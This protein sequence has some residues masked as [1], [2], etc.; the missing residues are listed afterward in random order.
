[1]K[2]LFVLLAVATILSA[3]N[4]GGEG[5]LTGVL[6]RAPSYDQTPYGMTRVPTGSFT[7]GPSDQDVPWALNAKAKTVSLT[8]FWMDQTEI[9]NNEYRQFVYWVRDSLAYRLL[10]EQID[11]YFISENKF[12]ETIDPPLIDWSKEI[13]WGGQEEHE[14]LAPLFYPKNERFFNLKRIDTRK[15]IYHYFWI[16]YKQ[17]AQKFTFDN[18]IR[19]RYNYKT[20]QYDGEVYNEE[21]VKVPV[22]D[23]S[24]F[25]M[26]GE[27]PIYP[28]TLCWISDFTNSY[29]EPMANTYF[30][31]PSFDD[32]PVV[33]VNWVEAR[34][35]CIWRTRLKNNALRA[36][37][38]NATNNYQL[39][40]EA[41][42]EYAARGGLQLVAYPWGGYYTR[43]DEG[44]FMANYKPLRGN[45]AEDGE[46]TTRKTASYEAN[47]Y[48]LYDMAGNVSEW[49][50]NAFDESA[51]SF[52]HDMNPDYEYNALPSDPPVL[53]R[54][55]I[56]GG[57]WKDIGYFL[58][59]GTRSY[60]YQDTA[61]S[62][63]GFRC[64]RAYLGASE[65]ALS[66][67]IY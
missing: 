22:K 54:K 12:G 32:Y 46:T 61:K 40:T 59:N 41:Q 31:N 37:G 23:R 53:K 33:G 51:Y 9:T 11:E 5:E 48:G 67:N 36:N 60:E 62:Y 15:L 25:I 2:K 10:G 45:Y 1:M 56:R 17:A 52:T 28:D 13:N 57:S 7:M 39:P 4:S 18:Q 8:A 21:G 44:C 58:Q 24:S 50:R 26:E 16:D 43:D 38:Q 66:S 3:C 27:T 35:F 14:I 34:A 64:V 29:N 19:R 55:V 49:T 47:D 65:D 6:G 30:S 63:I 42:W 20:G